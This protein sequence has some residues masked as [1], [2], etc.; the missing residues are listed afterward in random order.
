MSIESKPE[1]KL[2]QSKPELR[3]IYKTLDL[4]EGY[5][6]WKK[7]LP[8]KIGPWEDS[9][10]LFDNVQKAV[11]EQVKDKVLTFK[12]KI[13]AISE[14]SE[15]DI[16]DALVNNWFE[17]VPETEGQRREVLLMVAAHVIKHMETSAYQEIIANASENE[18][19]KLGLNS[20]LRDVATKTLDASMRVDNLF[21]RSSAFS[22]LSPKA[23]EQATLS[24]FYLPS[25][26]NPHTINELFPRDTQY[27]SRK[28]KEISEMPVDWK[29]I[30]GGETFKEYSNA[31]SIAYQEKDVDKIDACYEKVNELY[32]KSALSDFPVLIV[33]PEYTWTYSP[34]Y[35]QQELR[36]CLKDK[37]CIEKEKNIL[38]IQKTMAEALK[39]NDY[40]EL[41]KTVEEKKI[42]VVN[43]TGDY[44]VN[45]SAK[46]IAQEGDPIIIIYLGEQKKVYRKMLE[47]KN[48]KIEGMDEK[49]GEEINFLTTALHE[50]GHCHKNED[51]ALERF[52]EEAKIIIEDAKAEQIYR[53]LMPQ[54]IKQGSIDEDRKQLAIGMVENS[55]EWI[56]D[57]PE[58]DPYYSA[59]IYTLNKLV[60][61]KIVDFDFKTGTASIKDVDGFYKANKELSKNVLGLYKDES[62]NEKKAAKWVKQNCSP[63]KTVQ[64]ISDF[65][66]KD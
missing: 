38:S 20:E 42:K 34:P 19:E 51:P 36:V 18:L 29:R 13:P 40:P 25:D 59:A 3:N 37:N 47:D 27:I 57:S 28:F 35:H 53:W 1:E 45:L 55:L 15:E 41:G 58:D 65:V 61:Q 39:K 62:M 23:P 56:F 48:F 10:E 44:G 43:S 50:L 8:E 9:L 30:P 31:L 22:G 17:G 6:E 2:I 63:N 33:P 54:M 64:K 32:G 46:A 12:D 24:H 49:R 21:I 66:K 5:T 14:I 60:E 52:G 16:T 7:D 26:K 11:L 4:L